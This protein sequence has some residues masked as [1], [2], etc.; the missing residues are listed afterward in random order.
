MSNDVNWWRHDVGGTHCGRHVRCCTVSKR[1]AQIRT[2]WWDLGLEHVESHMGKPDSLGCI[3]DVS[4]W[5]ENRNHRVRWQLKYTYKYKFYINKK[6]WPTFSVSFSWVI[7]FQTACGRPGGMQTD[8]D[9]A[10]ASLNFHCHHY[11]DELTLIRLKSESQPTNSASGSG[12][13][14]CASWVSRSPRGGGGGGYSVRKMM[15]VCRWPL[16]IGPKKIVA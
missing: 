5:V 1:H 4:Y 7:S 16:K 14:G 8:I 15:G 11:N 9:K 3:A 13:P 6:P 2:D 12:S 10:R